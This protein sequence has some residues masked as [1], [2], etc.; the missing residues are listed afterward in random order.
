MCVIVLAVVVVGGVH[1]KLSAS[2]VI[3]VSYLCVC[4]AGEI[5][6]V[7]SVTTPN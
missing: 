7:L 2:K 5:F 1:G 6:T 4:S 3:C